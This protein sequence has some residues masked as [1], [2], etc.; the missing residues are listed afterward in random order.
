MS[1]GTTVLTLRTVFMNAPT[2][3]ADVR[4]VLMSTWTAFM[5]VPPVVMSA[6]RVVVLLFPAVSDL[7]TARTAQDPSR[8][9]LVARFALRFQLGAE[10]FELEAV[11]FQLAASNGQPADPT[12]RLE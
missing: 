5:S 11:R 4:Q 12:L 7:R 8:E 10:P 6:L 1:A 9:M 2:T 3:V